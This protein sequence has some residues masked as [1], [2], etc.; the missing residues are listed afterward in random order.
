MRL[1]VLAACL[2]LLLAGCAEQAVPSIAGGDPER[3]R[4]AILRH[5]CVSCHV[6]PGIAG[7]PSSVGPPLDQIARR[8][9]IGGVLPNQPTELVR[10]L[11]DPPQADPR[12]AMPNMGLSDAEATDIAAYLSTLD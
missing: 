6:I 3:G 1:S 7:P 10:W 9:Y 12:T 2:S 4:Q 5:G 8:A 11:L